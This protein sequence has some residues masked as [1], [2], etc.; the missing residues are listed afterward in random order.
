[1]AF[2]NAWADVQMGQPDIHVGAIWQYR[3]IDGFTNETVYKFS[4][5]V[6]SVN[7]HEIV[8]QLKNTIKEGA[9]LRY[10]TR[11]WNP[12]DVGDIKFDPFRPEFKF[13]MSIGGTWNLNFGLTE[14]GRSFLSLFKGKIVALEKV[15]VPAG[16]FDAYRI[17]IDAETRG[18]DANAHVS[19]SHIITWYSPE[20]QKYIRRESTTSS[21]GRVRNKNIDELIEYSLKANP[22]TTNENTSE[23][24][25]P[26]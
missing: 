22:G 15:T 9:W 23:S 3:K 26:F 2:T 11:E 13:P 5:R 20:V 8:I 10:F 19:N 4:Q 7:D 24:G 1:M 16:T 17:E 25:A 21:D 18:T 12:V 14:H 6:V